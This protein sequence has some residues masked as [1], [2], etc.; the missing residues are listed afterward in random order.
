MAFMATDDYGELRRSEATSRVG[1]AIGLIV[2]GAFYLLTGLWFIFTGVFAGSV[3]N[4]PEFQRNMAEKAKQD[5][6]RMT[7]EEEKKFRA[8]TENMFTYIGFGYGIWGFG[9]TILG[10]VGICGAISMLNLK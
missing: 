3:L 2:V 8:V 4:T 5:N 9:Q 1:P 10:G 7:R 6:P